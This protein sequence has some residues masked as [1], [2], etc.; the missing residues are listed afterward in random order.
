MKMSPP[1]QN[2]FPFP[3]VYLVSLLVSS[4]T[5]AATVPATATVSAPA[6]TATA[7]PAPTPTPAPAAIAPPFVVVPAIDGTVVGT[8][9]R[10]HSLGL[11]E[12]DARLGFRIRV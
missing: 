7:A 12:W 11:R 10:V 5:A 4:T 9:V 3:V 2:D 6:P 8:E 1:N